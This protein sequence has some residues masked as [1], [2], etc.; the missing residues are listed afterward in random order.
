MSGSPCAIGYAHGKAYADEIALLTEERMRLS[1]DPFWT[2]GRAVTHADVVAAGEACVAHHRAFS[3][4]SW[5]RSR[6][7]PTP[8][9]SASTNWWS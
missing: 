4:R 5:R 1:S 6:G 3:P 8:P 9:V 7:W 2:G